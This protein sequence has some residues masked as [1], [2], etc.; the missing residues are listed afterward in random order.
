MP[1]KTKNGA[2]I[3]TG[4]IFVRDVRKKPESQFDSVLWRDGFEVV[5]GFQ[6]PAFSTSDPGVVPLPD[7]ADERV[8]TNTEGKEVTARLRSVTTGK[9]NFT[10]PDGSPFVYEIEKLIEEDRA[11]IEK[12]SQRM[13]EA[14]RVVK[15]AS[16]PARKSLRYQSDFLWWDESKQ[17]ATISANSGISVGI[18]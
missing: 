3:L 4:L 1:K 8:W 13:A 7:L 6:L 14:G 5:D 12:G 10:L 18:W 15:N 17:S 11:F 16:I 2:P 9:G